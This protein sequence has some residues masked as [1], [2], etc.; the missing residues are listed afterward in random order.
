MCLS[1]LPTMQIEIINNNKCVK[2]FCL[3][4]P[5]LWFFWNKIYI[6]LICHSPKFLNLP[7]LYCVQE[8]F[9]EHKK[10]IVPSLGTIRLCS[11]LEKEKYLNLWIID[12]A[13]I[14]VNQFTMA[15]F[16]FASNPERSEWRS[17]LPVKPACYRVQN[18]LNLG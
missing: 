15:I 12:K 10:I 4:M 18:I 3:T 16:S 7:T 11:K 6:F 13:F 9:Y 5:L 17:R 2:C 14:L 8:I 1:N